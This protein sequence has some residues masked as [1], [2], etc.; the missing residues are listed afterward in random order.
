MKYRKTEV[1]ENLFEADGTNG[2]RLEVHEEGTWCVY[3][4]KFL[5]EP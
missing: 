5:V 4:E 3:D 1:D 2:K